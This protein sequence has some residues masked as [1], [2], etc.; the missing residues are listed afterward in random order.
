LLQIRKQHLLKIALAWLLAQKPWIVPIP[1][2]T[3]VECLKENLGSTD[4]KLTAEESQNI[5]SALDKIKIMGD[6]YP[7]ELEKRIGI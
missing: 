4:I 2:T 1:G 5:N 7:E 3:K 6:R